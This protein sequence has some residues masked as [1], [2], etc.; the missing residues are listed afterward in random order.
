MSEELSTNID[1]Y[2]I[3]ELLELIQLKEP[4]TDYDVHK[5]IVTTQSA[6]GN[7][8]TIITFFNDAKKKLLSNLKNKSNNILI[9]Y[10]ST[11]NDDEFNN[12]KIKLLNENN[13]KFFNRDLIK[14]SIFIDTKHIFLKNQYPYGINPDPVYNFDSTLNGSK[15]YFKLNLEVEE[16]EVIQLSLSNLEFSNTW[17]PI[18]YELGNTC[19]YIN[20]NKIEIEPGVPDI[21]K[22]FDDLNDKISALD[23]SCSFQYNLDTTT[24]GYG[25]N[26]QGNVIFNNNSTSSIIFSLTDTTTNYDNGNDDLLSIQRSLGWVFGFRNKSYNIDA[27]SVIYSESL[28]DLRT[29][30]YFYILFEDYNNTSYSTINIYKNPSNKLNE[31]SILSRI[32]VNGSSLENVNREQI[33]NTV[34]V[35][36]Q[37]NGKVNLL[38]I[39][40]SLRD[41][42]GNIINLNNG[43]YSFS[44][45]IEKLNNN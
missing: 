28:L 23:L 1:D 33:N 7:E 9:D 19:I 30:K 13:F 17:Y 6:F 14:K 27:S 21:T 37:Y 39:I 11:E 12:Q 25:P 26:G 5:N 4:Y 45:D 35:T 34:S 22:I 36:K 24:L 10:S 38:S 31:S 29:L 42:Y 15:S 3:K 8:Q 43:D 32:S 20:D 44:I 40:V 41:E 2:T 18:S 16:K